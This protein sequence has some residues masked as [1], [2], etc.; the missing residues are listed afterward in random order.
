MTTIWEIDEDDH[1]IEGLDDNGRPDPAYAASL[2][3]T[4]A[5]MM[6]RA[7]AFAVDIVAFWI[8]QLPLLLFAMPLIVLYLTGGVSLYGLIYHPRFV[9]AA[10]MA[11]VSVVLLIALGIAQLVAHGRRGTSIGKAFFGVRSVNIATL[12]RPGF[13]RIVLRLIVFVASGIVVVGPLLMV[14]SSFWDPAGRRR[15]WHD[16]AGGVWL[17]D[18]KRGLNPYD[19]KRMRIARKAVRVETAPEREA[20]ISLATPSGESER[21]EYRPVARVSSGVLGMAR[22]TTD[23]RRD[24]PA[25]EQASVVLGVPGGLRGAPPAQPAPQPPAPSAPAP[26]AAQPQ[27]PAPVPAVAYELEIDSGQRVRVGGLIVLGRAPRAE[28][29]PQGVSRVAIPDDTRSI[30]KTH[31]SARPLDDGVEIVDLDSTNGCEIER[32]GQTRAIPPRTP[33]RAIPGDVVR[34]GDRSLVIIAAPTD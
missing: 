23:P 5:P 31:L 29:V 17:V 8:V 15:G 1:E 32:A 33:I 25:P 2:G 4:R 14:L 18:I 24:G 12:E 9:L 34:F 19:E 20:R 22:A 27:A 16:Y 28:D 13:W 26:A 6:R 30:S 11:G 10:I 7:A 21:G 3:L